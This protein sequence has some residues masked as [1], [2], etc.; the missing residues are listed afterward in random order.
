MNSKL[1]GIG[2][3]AMAAGVA[4]LAC[5]CSALASADTLGAPTDGAI[6]L[7]PAAS[8]IRRDVIAFHDHIL[9]PIIVGISL[10]V[11]V[12]LL[13]CI[14][15][16]NHRAN[17]TPARWSH[18]TPVEVAW[19]IIPVLIL[20]F[21]AIFSFRLLFEEHDMPRPYMTVK[22]T[23]R[24]WNWDYE[25]PDQKIPAYTSTLMSEADAAAKRLPYK[26]ATNAPMVAPVGKVVR[27]LVTGEDVIHSFSVP[28]FGVK[29]DAVPGRLNDTWF[30]ADRTGVFYGQ[31]SQ[32]C[33]I[34]HAFMPIEVKVVTQPEFDAWVASKRPKASL[35]QASP[36]V[37]VPTAAAGAAP[38]AR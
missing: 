36:N 20:M 38:V 19:T 25:Y 16:F 34:D 9:L 14:V 18:N 17:P 26:L 27:V 31:C 3:L 32:L 10:L 28:A 6:D 37:P 21:I 29:I 23:G 11:L 7:Q 30:K 22:V 4:A 5:A 33:G 13:I 35:A 24:Q 2:R 15:R 12:L 8:Q 1:A